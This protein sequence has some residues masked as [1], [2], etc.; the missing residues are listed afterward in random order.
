MQAI[1]AEYH[2][3][4]TAFVYSRGEDFDIRWFT[5]ECEVDLCGHA[6]LAA[7]R[8]LWTEMPQRREIRFHYRRGQL[9]VW[10]AEDGRLWLR[11][12]EDPPR[13]CDIPDG[14]AHALGC[15]IRACLQGR[16]DLLA[17][18]DDDTIL[19]RMRPDLDFIAHLPVRGLIVT[20]IAR[21]FAHADF[22]SR[23]FAPRIGIPEDPVTGSAHATLTPWWSEQWKRRSLLRARQL[24]SRGGDLLCAWRTPFVEIGGHATIVSRGEILL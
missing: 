17:W 8:V 21:S 1:A 23:F 24:S 7:A 11:L 15:E 5:P 10:Q 3:S 4:E 18:I 12:P 13:P 6:T 9:R 19:A 20:A 22:T 14:L 16:D 2:V